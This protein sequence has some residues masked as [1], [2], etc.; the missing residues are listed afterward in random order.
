MVNID[1]RCGD[2]RT[3]LYDYPDGYFSLIVTSPPYADARKRHY[4]SIKTS[5]YPEFMASFHAEF[6]RVLADDGSFVLNVK[7]KVVNGV[8]DRYVWKTI[9]VL[10]ELGW[11]CVDDYIWTK[12]NAMPGYWPNR[13]RDEWEYCFHMTKNR[14]FAMYQDQVKKPIGDW[15]KQRLK[16][17]NGKSAER[18]DSENNSGFGRDLRNW[19]NKK[20]VLPGN[21]VSIPLVGKNMGHPAAFPAGLPEFFVKLFSKEGDNILDPFAGSGTT[22]VV[23]RKLARNAVLIDT[24]EEY[25]NQMKK[26]IGAE[27]FAF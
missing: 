23:A 25:V 13:L 5:E 6:W 11:R 16:K 7:D 18:H 1:I 3:E 8:R 27:Q 15:T 17:L 10:S 19:V 22:G 24:S 14:K 9:E 26:R 2:S 20:S 21:N 12:P 4:D